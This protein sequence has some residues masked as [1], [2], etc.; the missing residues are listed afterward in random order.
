MPIVTIRIPQLG[1]GLEEALLV[2]VLK[3]PGDAVARDEPLYVMETDKATTDVESPYSGTLVEWTADTGSV[4]AI[5]SEIA[6]MDIADQASEQTTDDS[7]GGASESVISSDSSGGGSGGQEKVATRND[8]SLDS[9]SNNQ[10][11][12][13]LIPPRTRKYL[14]E[15]GL[16]EQA[17]SIPVRGSKMM[18]EDVDAFL[19][20]KQPE[21]ERKI[22]DGTAAGEESDYETLALPTSQVSLNYRM[23]RGTGACIPVTVVTDWDWTNIQSVRSRL[24]ADQDASEFCLACWAIVQAM[25]QHAKLR[26]VLAAD[27]KTLKVYK[28]VNLGIAVALPEDEMLTAVVRQADQMS[29]SEFCA[30]FRQQVELAKTGRDQ[31]DEK[32]TLTVSNIGKAGMR[33]GIPAIVAPAVATLAIGQVVS[34]PIA[35]GDSFRFVPMASATL[36]FD[37]RIVNG[38]GAANFMNDIRRAIE[39]I[40]T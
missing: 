4:L 29:L 16:L 2:E 30:A 14:K 17:D 21:S 36:C 39:D 34:H 10:R 38:V 33:I 12:A 24:P 22:A 13:V 15:Q 9:E 8:A 18:P 3:Q 25:T 23:A 37:H 32:T 1:E 20:A 27:G 19:R 40:S 11:S 5:G 26:S 28:H 6:R 35:Q 31:A 7:S